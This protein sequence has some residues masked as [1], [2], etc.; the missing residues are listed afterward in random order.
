MCLP[1]HNI[2]DV[3]VSSLK[4]EH[5]NFKDL[6]GTLVSPSGKKV[7]LW[8]NVCPVQ[9]N[10]QILIDDQAPNPFSCANTTNGQYRPK[11]KLELFNG[12]NAT[13]VWTLEVKDNV[14]SNGGKLN[15]F[16]LEICASVP[17][18]DPYL[19]KDNLLE[20]FHNEVKTIGNDLLLV[21]D[22]NNTASQL[23]FTV[24]KT[25]AYGNILLNNAVLNI[26]STF[27]QD[28]INNNRLTFA[29]TGN[30]QLPIN[31]GS[32]LPRKRQRRWLAWHQ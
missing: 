18:E 11:E 29:Y 30:V 13:G 26:G 9:L 23:V 17:V 4:I 22:K 21:E 28:D 25:P 12:E 1:E 24:V 20:C 7:V 14:S 16:E 2:S 27:T 3:N 8:S 10:I 15:A 5:V 32:Q 31:D 6:T 19:S